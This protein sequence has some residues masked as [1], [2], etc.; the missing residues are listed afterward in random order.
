[1]ALSTVV[2]SRGRNCS[3]Q[4]LEPLFGSVFASLLS[5]GGFAVCSHLQCRCWGVR[6]QHSIAL[7]AVPYLSMS[8][9]AYQLLGSQRLV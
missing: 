9:N 7:L 8:F 1:M 3:E 4:Q 2:I 6:S 5:G